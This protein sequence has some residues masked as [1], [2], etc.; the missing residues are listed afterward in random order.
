MKK[1]YLIVAITSLTILFGCSSSKDLTRLSPNQRLHEA[2]NEYNKEDYESALGQFQSILME[3]QG[4]EVIDSAQYY[5]AMCR[6][7]REE[8]IMA[9]YEFS[10]IIQNMPQSKLVPM[11]Q[12][13][14]AESYY[15]LSPKMPLDQKY[16]KKAID[17]LQAFID[18]YPRHEKI[19]EAAQK[20]KT[21]NNK[22]AEK[23]YKAAYIYEK[24]ENYNAA[25]Y[26][27]G[28]ILE[29]YH[30]SKIAP[31]SLCDKIRLLIL[32]GRIPEA[33]ID[34]ENFKKKYSNN[35]NYAKVLEF[36][37]QIAKK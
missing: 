1:L 31:Q 33:Q 16:T 9:S 23:D 14:L 22:L 8:F 18:F 27:H 26:Y 32:K 10:K 35:E 28:L 2:V 36:E 25:I 7:K 15:N 30:D 21:L 11:S 20:I 19:A 13:M 24:M 3:F 37:K 4:R 5:L 34:I 17:E 6:F 29:T 12:Y